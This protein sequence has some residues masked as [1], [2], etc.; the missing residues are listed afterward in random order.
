MHCTST[1]SLFANPVAFDADE[2]VGGG[3]GEREIW[4]R[5][6]NIYHPRGYSWEG[7]TDGFVANRGAFAATTRAL[8]GGTTNAG[9]NALLNTTANAF[10]GWERKETVGNLG[11]LPIF[12]S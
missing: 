9:V 1:I 6:G 2:S 12:H 3:A 4:Y 11:I 10:Q 8:A 7:R 5:W